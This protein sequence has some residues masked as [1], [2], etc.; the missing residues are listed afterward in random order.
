[1]TSALIVPY[2]DRARYLE[3]FLR[4]VPRYLESRSHDYVI[5]VA[6]QD[7]GDVWNAALARNMG[8]LAALADGG[9][10]QLVF[11]DVDML[12]VSGVDYN[13]QEFNVAWLTSVGGYKVL[14]ADFIAAN[15]WNPDYPGW[16]YGDGELCKR[17]DFLNLPWR[18]AYN[19]PEHQTA[20]MY[21]LEL[22]PD[23]P[24]EGITKTVFQHVGRFL[25]YPGPLDR[26]SKDDKYYESELTEISRAMF[27]EFLAMEPAAMTAYIAA[28]GLNRCRL[29]SAR[30]TVE[31][32]VHWVRFSA[33]EALQ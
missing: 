10:N 13:R 25:P 7:A 30:R 23:A 16:G 8:A 4:E 9:F 32:G 33:A 2:R 14:P 31:D 18:F 29:S 17:L 11:Q 22:P 6:E 26:H 5:Y 19:M 28:N 12:P 24:P 1:M 27:R 15:G 21:D 20:V 3:A